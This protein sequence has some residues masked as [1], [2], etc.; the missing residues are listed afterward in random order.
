MQ[1]RLAT[2]AIDK[3]SILRYAKGIL[4]LVSCLV[5]LTGCNSHPALP[6]QSEVTGQPVHILPDYEDVTI[7]PNIAPL[8]FSVQGDSITQSVAQIVYPGGSMTYGK[9]RKVII[10]AD[11]WR[12]MLSLSVGQSLRVQLYTEVAG[13]WRQHPAF[14]IHVAPDSIDGYVSYRLI[15]PYNTYERISLCQR[16]LSDFTEVEYYNNQ[17]LDTPQRGH[18]VNCHAFQ[19]Y[20][21]E[22]MQFHV[23]EEHGGTI[24]YDHGQLGKY[25]MKLPETISG[26]VYPAWHPSLD[27]IAYSTNLPFL[28][29]HTDGLTKSEVQDSES[30]LILYDVANRRVIP[31]CNEADRLETFPSWSPDGKWLYYSVAEFTFSTDQSSNVSKEVRLFRQHDITERYHEVHYDIYRRS[32]DA[33]TLSFG[34]PEP[35]LLAS[36]NTMSATLPRISPDGRWLLTSI[37][38][39]GCFHVYHPE[40]D[41]YVTDLQTAPDSIKAQTD[42]LSSKCD[43][44]GISTSLTQANSDRAESYHNWSSNGRWIVFQSRRRDNNYTR[45]YFAWFDAEGHAHKAFELPQRDP[46]YELLHLNSYNIPEFTIEPVRTTPAQLAKTILSIT[47]PNNNNTK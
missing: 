46:D 22:R 29:V 20:R 19:N 32:F 21:T 47:I 4:A 39:E 14:D 40:A 9:G 6:T 27:L 42:S 3:Q 18:C 25:N 8:N 34:E 38:N 26:G 43:V 5:L 44:V 41:L 33:S 2:R 1:A 30:G 11:E 17:M 35:V 12:Q 10:D 28:E 13:Q 31:I 45:L 23:R 16:S 36:A 37:G 15:P 7:P 24:I